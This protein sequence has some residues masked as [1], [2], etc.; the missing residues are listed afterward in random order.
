MGLE[1]VKHSVKNEHYGSSLQ[2]DKELG[3]QKADR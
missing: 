2:K 1:K 3:I